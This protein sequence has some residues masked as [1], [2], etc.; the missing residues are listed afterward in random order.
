M[1]SKREA[2]KKQLNRKTE[3]Q[4]LIARLK[5]RGHQPWVKPNRDGGRK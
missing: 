3:Y 1:K 4:R 5:K 2:I